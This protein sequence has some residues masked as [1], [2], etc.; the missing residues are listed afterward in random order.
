MN[1][2]ILELADQAL[3]ACDAAKE[4]GIA[5]YSKRFAELIIG[6]CLMLAQSHP[7]QMADYADGI[8]SVRESIKEHF[9]VDE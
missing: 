4:R 2:R 9:G 7:S 6:E 3:K 1:E 5:E 8:D